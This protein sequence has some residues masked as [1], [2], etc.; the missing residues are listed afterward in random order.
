MMEARNILGREDL[1]CINKALA[2]GCDVRIQRVKDGYRIVSER[3]KVL[4]RKPD[5]ENRTEDQR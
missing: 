5:T 3:T 2:A 1:P 4:K